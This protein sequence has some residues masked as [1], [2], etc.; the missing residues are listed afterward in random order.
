[1]GW[2]GGGVRNRT[3]Y[4]LLLINYDVFRCKNL[5]N[6]LRGPQRMVQNDKKDSS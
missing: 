2:G 5:D 3:E 1:M 4:S 6:I